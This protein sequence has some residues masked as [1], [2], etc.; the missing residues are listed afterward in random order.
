MQQRTTKLLLIFLVVAAGL[1]GQNIEIDGLIKGELKMT[2][3]SI[4]FKNNSVDYAAMPY[5]V[6]S[7][8]KYIATHIKDIKSFVIWRDSSEKDQL[9]KRRIKKLKADL[10][11][12][13]PADII[14]IQT[15]GKTQKISQSTIHKGVDY[16]QIQYLLSLNSVFDIY[17]TGVLTEKKRTKKSHI[18]RP[19]LWCLKCWKNRRFSK[20]Y[21]RLHVK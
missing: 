12:Y 10:N 16:K 19:R 14:D 2:F 18:E 17:T 6:D 4:Y 1:Q 7:C 5:T 20:D 9:T 21:R 8:F 13:T 3:P 15:M 11:K